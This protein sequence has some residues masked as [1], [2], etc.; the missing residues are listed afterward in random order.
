MWHRS[1]VLIKLNSI[2]M[3]LLYL[4]R[5]SVNVLYVAASKL[6]DGAFQVSQ[7]NLIYQQSRLRDLSFPQKWPS[8]LMTT[9]LI[10][11]LPWHLIGRYLNKYPE[12]EALGDMWGWKYTENFLYQWR[13]C[14][15]LRPLLFFS[16]QY[17]LPKNPHEIPF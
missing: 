1:S 12:L 14:T 9:A 13:S 17:F 10:Q 5:G 7:G 4:F 16:V 3:Y 11:I 8:T 6:S 2:L 15:E